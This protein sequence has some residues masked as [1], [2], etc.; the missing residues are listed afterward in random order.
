MADDSTIYEALLAVQAAAPTLPKDKEGQVGTRK[1][2]YT[3]L[4]TIVEIVGPILREHGLVWFTK[5]TGTHVEPM[6]HYELMHPASGQRIVGVMPLMLEGDATSQ[7]FG[8]ALTYARR[9]GLCAVLN[10]VA[11]ED[12]DGHA[13]STAGRSTAR[14]PSRPGKPS[15]EQAKLIK[16]LVTQKRASPEQLRIMLDTIGVTAAIEPGWIDELSPGKEGTASQLITWLMERPLPSIEHPS[17][18]NM[19]SADEF[20]HPKDDGSGTP[21]EDDEGTLPLVDR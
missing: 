10:L 19:A 4:H 14:S 3:D 15:G 18:L 7:K 8:S 6:L 12:D 20:V 21:L 13:A 5:P 16:K 2:R 1:Y 9:Y 11:D 17:D